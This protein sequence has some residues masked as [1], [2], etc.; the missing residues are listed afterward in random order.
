MIGL[1]PVLVL[2]DRGYEDCIQI[3]KIHAICQYS[4]IARK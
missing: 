3:K 2:I 4:T 1:E